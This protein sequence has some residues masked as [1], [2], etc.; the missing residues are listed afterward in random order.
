MQDG[1]DRFELDLG[2]SLLGPIPPHPEDDRTDVRFRVWAPRRQA[3]AVEFQQAGRTQVRSLERQAGGYFSADITG[4]PT[5][6][7]YR[8]LLDDDVRRP[9]PASRF[10]PQ[11]VHGWSQVIDPRRFPWRD[12][13]WPGLAR[14]DLIIYEVHVGTFTAAGTFRG[15]VERIPELLELG[16]TAI[17]LMPIAQCPG[18]WN[19]GYDGVNWFAVSHAYGTP[20]ELRELVDACHRAGIAVLLDVVYNHLGP[21]GNY[22]NDFGPYFSHKHRTPWG[23]ALGYDGKYA[24]HVRHYVISNALYWLHEYHF[25]GLRLDAVHFMF[26]DSRVPVCHELSAAVRRLGRQL[27]RQL[28]VIGESNVFDRRLLRGGAVGPVSQNDDRGAS[29]SRTLFEEVQAKLGA[30]DGS[31]SP[32]VAELAGEELGLDA[33]WCDDF[34]HAALSLAH[35]GKQL[36]HRRYDGASDFAEVLYHGYLYELV[37]PNQPYRRATAGDRQ[38]VADL[39]A[40]VVGIQNHDT[41]G[42]HP[43]GERL[44]QSTSREFQR[45]LAALMLLYP[46]LPIL[47][48]G[49]EFAASAP[50]LFFVDF[51]DQHLREAVVRG[52]AREYAHHDWRDA[53]SP[54]ADEAFYRSKRGEIQEGDA[55]T[56]AWYRSLIAIRKRWRRMGLL[57]DRSLSVAADSRG[58]FL[59]Q[60]RDPSHPAR[61]AFVAARLTA[62]RAP[63]GMPATVALDFVGSL[64][65]DSNRPREIVPDETLGERRG[66]LDLA[67]NQAVVGF[68]AVDLQ[69]TLN[70]SERRFPPPRQ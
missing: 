20:D 28:L 43:H 14:D 63:A 19:W 10:Q 37:E 42:N 2:A 62:A 48:M 52:R 55:A 18:R 45:S 50:F 16:V 51:Q 24:R 30:D 69:G 26:D 57:S 23:P 70:W 17:E 1:F 41:I 34:M 44:A 67:L 5:G 54:L 11:G 49:E 15:A 66:Q 61:S 46:T 39:P 60:Y 56:W 4:L 27:G 6:T 40:L 58:L 21:E 35:E 65:A 9:D 22:L 32:A 64:M 25:D 7:L 31:D 33:I 68:G 12:G 53:P 38:L 47:F 36:S 29:R 8:Y 13:S 59:L 3:V